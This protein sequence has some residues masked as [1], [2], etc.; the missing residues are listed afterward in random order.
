MGIYDLSGNEL[1]AKSRKSLLGNYFH[2]SFDD[3]R[4]CTANLVNNI[5]T[6][7]WNEPFLGWLKGL[8]EQYG[9]VFSLYLYDIS[10]LTNVPATYKNELFAAREWLK[11][12]PHAAINNN[13]TFEN[14]TAEVGAAAWDTVVT[15]VIRFAGSP[16]S[17]DRIPRLDRFKGSLAALTAMRDC[18]CGALGFLSTDDSRAPY[19]LTQVQYEYLQEHD[20]F[21][22]DTNGLY[23]LHTDMRGDWFLDSFTSEYTYR[24]PTE[25]N[26]YDDLV[27]RYN[28][29]IESDTF[30]AYIWFTHE[31][32]VY[33]NGALN[34]NK[35]WVED[36]CK[37]A[38]D[39]EI[40]FDYPQNRLTEIT[41][42]M[43]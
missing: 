5:Y 36:A 1:T 25:T 27:Q 40:P 14:A 24:E 38:Y 2:L 43:L 41:S 34:S 9:A 12:S 21:I 13:A 18:D 17:I 35:K 42:L 3:V 33:E 20:I 6:S 7:I 31:W 19:Y 37:F 26:V 29:S 32:Q 22:D 39:Y 8:H 4:L 23:F 11:F 10:N 16:Q 30:R 15:N 28:A